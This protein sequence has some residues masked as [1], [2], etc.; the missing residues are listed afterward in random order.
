M[1][2]AQEEY[3]RLLRDPRWQK[4]RLEIFRRDGWQCQNCDNGLESGVEL[5]VHHLAYLG[6]PW[7]AGD[8]D[9][10]TRCAECH[11]REHAVP[12]MSLQEL[13]ARTRFLRDKLAAASLDVSKVLRAAA[14]LREDLV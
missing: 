6:N 11:D 2:P 13:D 5:H 1:E 7:D 8:E 3:F 10:S 9:L 12:G 14:K 4:R